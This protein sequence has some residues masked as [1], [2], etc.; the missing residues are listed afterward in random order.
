M[1]RVTSF[2]IRPYAATF[3]FDRC[4][5]NECYNVNCFYNKF[6]TQRIRLR[7]TELRLLKDKLINVRYGDN[8]ILLNMFCLSRNEKSL[9]LK[10]FTIKKLICSI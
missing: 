2:G 5:S 1:I 6:S 3:T 7:M 9:Y 10:C 4:D 8:C